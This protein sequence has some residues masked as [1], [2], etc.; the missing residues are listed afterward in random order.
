MGSEGKGGIG[1]LVA[2]AQRLV[3]SLMV[4]VPLEILGDLLDIGQGR[5]AMDLEAFFFLGTMKPFDKRI[6]IGSVRRADDDLD[7]QT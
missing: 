3:R 5:R 7:A 6:F 1:W 4:V 2:A